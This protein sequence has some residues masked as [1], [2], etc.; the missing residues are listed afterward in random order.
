MSLS[1]ASLRA[2]HAAL[3]SEPVN[4]ARQAFEQQKL[5]SFPFLRF[6]WLAVRSTCCRYSLNA[7]LKAREGAAV[8]EAVMH[9]LT[10]SIQAHASEHAYGRAR[11]TRRGRAARGKARTV[12]CQY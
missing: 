9:P 12:D 5:E 11:P 10:H 7:R 6:L 2:L 1:V 8:H 3:H 4:C